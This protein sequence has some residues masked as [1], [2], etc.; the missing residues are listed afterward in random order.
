MYKNL[1]KLQKIDD[2]KIELKKNSDY[3]FTEVYIIWPRTLDAPD[4]YRVCYV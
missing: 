3:F 4:D 2:K 1:N